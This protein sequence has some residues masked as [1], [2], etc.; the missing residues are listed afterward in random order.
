MSVTP[1]DTP[2]PVANANT[3]NG[4]STNGHSTNGTITG[5]EDNTN[6]TTMDS[7]T[8]VPMV[9]GPTVVIHQISN[10]SGEPK[11]IVLDE[12]GNEIV[13]DDDELEEEELK[14]QGVCASIWNLGISLPGLVG[15]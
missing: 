6:G 9:V 4:H 2:L 1:T 14:Q 10:E 11:K 15:T 13:L 12:N 3:T 5:K 8:G 7:T